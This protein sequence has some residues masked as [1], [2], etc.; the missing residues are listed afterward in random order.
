MNQQGERKLKKQERSKKIQQIVI[1]KK[2]METSAQVR[3]ALTVQENLLQID[4]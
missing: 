4:S 2:L 1:S 3:V